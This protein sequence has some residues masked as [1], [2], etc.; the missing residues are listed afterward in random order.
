MKPVG[1]WMPISR[2][3]RQ[4]GCSTAGCAFAAFG[5]NAVFQVS[6]KNDVGMAAGLGVC[7]A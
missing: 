7:W 2:D 1:Q 6:L 3:V 4:G 5:L